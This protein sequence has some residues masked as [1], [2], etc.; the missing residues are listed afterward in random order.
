L[1]PGHHLRGR[2]VGTRAFLSFRIAE[3]SREE[4]DLVQMSARQA[5]E[6][7][8]AGEVTSQELV[9]ACLDRIAELED[10][11][12]A[13][14]HLDP[15]HA[16]KQARDR[17][18]SR[19]EGKDVGSLHGIP[20]GVKDIFDTLDMPTEDGTVLHA[21]RQTVADATVVA[22]LREA[23]A[24]IMGKTVT[25][26]LAV[27]TP[28]KT[29]NPHDFARTPGG[30][31]SGSAAAVAAFMV[32]LAIGTQTNGSV[33]RPASYCGVYGYKP[34][35]GLISRHGVLRQSRPLDQ[36]GVFA[37]NVEDAA[38]I[39]EQLMAFDDRDPDMRPRARLKLAET[40]STEPPF[41]PRFAFVKSPVW[42]Q[43]EED[44]KA[45][46][47]EL[48]E[49]LGEN[50]REV[51]LPAIFNE[52]VAWHRAVMEADLAR[53]FAREYARGKDQL[54]ATLREMIERGQ[55]VLAMDYNRAVDQIST[56]NGMLEEIFEWHDA[57][58]TPAATGEAPAGLEST[59][60]PIFCTLW[61]L[62]GMPA[63]SLPILQGAHGLPMGV[64]LVGPRF[65]DAKLLRS[66]RWLV[67]LVV[68]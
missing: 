19:R 32:P 1:A 2:E 3:G 12:G 63:I 44:M 27:Y 62:C 50:V 40:A 7:I 58:L 16:L 64:Q 31:S 49:H 45:A 20:V 34:S 24:V 25:T 26:E 14:A 28:G 41:P 18:L 67:N 35:H 33:I 13:W 22:L 11:V 55:K 66:V 46:F 10:R 59:G 30:S 4:M 36:V 23:G 68:H 53:S 60:S 65:D 56:L 38:L 51:E 37:R 9:R 5:A 61:T 8:R 48:A 54:S 43:A 47:A 42:D 17:D 21:G 52:A 57:I 29:R 15:D 39:A 6:A